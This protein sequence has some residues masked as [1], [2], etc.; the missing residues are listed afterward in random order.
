MA[1][2]HPVGTLKAFGEHDSRI[3][4]RTRRSRNAPRIGPFVPCYC[5]STSMRFPTRERNGMHTELLEAGT[6]TLPNLRHGSLASLGCRMQVG[7]Q[8][9]KVRQFV[10]PVFSPCAV[11]KSTV[12]LC[13]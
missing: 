5:R 4:G 8:A 6:D 12:E 9:T 10:E 1:T 11:R 13:G 2:S 7:A 3:L